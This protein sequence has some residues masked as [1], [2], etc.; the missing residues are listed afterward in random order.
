MH[1]QTAEDRANQGKKSHSDIAKEDNRGN[2]LNKKNI[3]CLAHGYEKR[4]RLQIDVIGQGFS[5]NASGKELVSSLTM[6]YNLKE[7]ILLDL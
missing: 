7:S 1:A 6:A 4:V 3:V 2:S 5:T